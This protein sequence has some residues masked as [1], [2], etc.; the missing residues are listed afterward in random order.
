MYQMVK[1]QNADR[2]EIKRI[3]RNQR[4]QKMMEA[5]AKEEELI[6]AFKADKALHRERINVIEIGDNAVVQ[7]TELPPG[8]T[9]EQVAQAE[10][11]RKLKLE[12]DEQEFQQ[13][14]AEEEAK[15][16]LQQKRALRNA[17]K[18]GIQIDSAT[19][20]MEQQLRDDALASKTDKL[21][22]KR[23]ADP[24]AVYLQHFKDLSFFANR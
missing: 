17:Q 23:A 7:K 14:Q 10:L 3:Y 15:R 6:R 5:R 21:S 24:N 11:E 22:S 8:V 4:Q 19:K 16:E 1:V 18:R 2:D 9:E 20:A 13:K 12:R